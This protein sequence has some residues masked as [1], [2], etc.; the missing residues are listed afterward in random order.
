MIWQSREGGDGRVSLLP[1]AILLLTTLQ[2][3]L[4]ICWSVWSVWIV[5]A[6]ITIITRAV[7]TLSLGSSHWMAPQAD[8][9]FF[10]HMA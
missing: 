1:S 7:G 10:P 2:N 3:S 5:S 4:L 6:S 9:S 8:H